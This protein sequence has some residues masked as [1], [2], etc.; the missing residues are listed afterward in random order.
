MNFRLIGAGLLLAGSLFGQN[1]TFEVASV[2]PAGPVNAAAIMS[3]QMRI[4]M[5]VD[6]ARVDIG[7]M[8]MADLIRVAYKVKPYQVSGPAWI[9]SERYSIQAKLPEGASTDQVPEMLQALLAERFHLQVHR[10][11]KEQSVLALI[12][13]KNGP[14]LKDS[15]PAK[16]G[17][18]PSAEDSSK[19]IT[20]NTGQGAVR[21]VG[22]PTQ[23]RGMSVTGGQFASMQ[24]SMTKEGI[25]HLESE[26]M[27]IPALVDILS[28]FNDRPVVDLTELKGTYQMALDVS[29]DELRKMARSAGVNVPAAAGAGAPGV[30]T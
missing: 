23:G 14:K 24:I 25:M 11:K 26:R 9:N 30:D 10:D 6:A 13:G 21:V 18:P 19:G 20:I 5:K 15:P 27:T 3:G 7:S 16:E 2:K 28:R 12:V 29:T 17:P 22:N 4:G 1:P 8:S